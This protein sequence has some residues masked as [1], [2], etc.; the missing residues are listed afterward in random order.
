MA[1]EEH[2]LKEPPYRLADTARGGWG[3]RCACGWRTPLFET[4]AE[5]LASGREHLLGEEASAASEGW[6]Q[7]RRRKKQRPPWEERRRD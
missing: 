2:L 6:W 7:R 4:E 3:M 1:E 5:A